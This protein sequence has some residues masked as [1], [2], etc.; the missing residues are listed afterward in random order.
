M[1]TYHSGKALSR[2]TG[3]QLAVLLFVLVALRV[4]LYFYGGR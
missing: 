2:L 4:G 1:S 3:K